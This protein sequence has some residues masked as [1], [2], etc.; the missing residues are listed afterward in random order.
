MERLERVTYD[1][2]RAFRCEP[3]VPI[4]RGE[5]P[6]DLDARR[7]VRL[8]TRR[9]EPDEADELSGGAMLRGIKPEASLAQTGSDAIGEAI[10]LCA[11]EQSRHELHHDQVGVEARERLFV[12]VAPLA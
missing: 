8:E 10:A 6:P 7:E 3:L 1:G 4:R 2:S 5:A 9:R 12:R 11:R